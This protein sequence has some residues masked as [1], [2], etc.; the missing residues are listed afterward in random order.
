[1]AKTIAIVG[2]LDTKHKEFAFIE[3]LIES[4]GFETLMIHSGVFES[5]ID[6]DIS[7]EMI[8]NAVGEDITS[9]A[10]ERDRSKGTAVLSDGLSVLLP[11]LYDEGE[12]EGVI[13]LGGSGGTAIATAGMRELPIGVPKVMVSTMAS[14]DV[15]QYVGTSDI[16]MIPSIVDVA[17]LNDISKHIFTNAVN[18]ICGMV[19]HDYMTDTGQKPLIA[20]SMFGLT[21]PAITK[22]TEIL[23]D[24]G[25]EVIV[26]H[27]TGTGG[28]TMESLIKNDYF[29]GV[30]DLTTTEWVDEL[31][32]GV[33]S[34]GADRLEAGVEMGLPQVISLGA[35]D[36]ANFGP[37]ETIPEQFSDRLFYQHNPSVTL[38]RTTIEENKELG[39]IVANKLKEANNAT[40][41]MIPTDGF[42]GLDEEG[43]EFYDVEAD[44]ALINSVKE[45]LMESD[46][47]IIEVDANINDDEFAE[48]AAKKLMK[49]IENKGA[50]A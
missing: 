15:S 31:V 2:T 33:L 21:T 46:I 50:S 4:Y 5:G 45:N 41:L 20:A 7:N 24:Q 37:K 47:T 9:I 11:K 18:A 22:A 19:E 28:K 32:G 25:Y 16:M 26:F 40:I 38:M 12:F 49:L 14:G 17:G 30:L 10:E 39:E 3:D 8:A 42:S 44:Q 23:E 35:M 27:A 13:S 29:A 6:A 36:M 34:A 43:K 48:T 1:V